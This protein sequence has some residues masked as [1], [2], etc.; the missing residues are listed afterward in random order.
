MLRI[1][2][3]ILKCCILN[4]EDRLVRRGWGEWYFPPSQRAHEYPPPPLNTLTVR[5]TYGESPD[6]DVEHEEGARPEVGGGDPQRL[7]RCL[8][9]ITSLIT[10]GLDHGIYIRWYLINRCAHKEQYPLFDLYK[11]FD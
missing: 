4:K 10:N 6:E 5:N 9:I 3:E 7:R 2:E 11:A 1:Y 8:V